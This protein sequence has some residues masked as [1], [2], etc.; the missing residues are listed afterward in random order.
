MPR[1]HAPLV[2]HRHVDLHHGVLDLLEVAAADGVLE[3]RVAGEDG[4]VVDHEADH[5]V[6]VPRRGH[7]IDPQITGFERVADD[8]HPELALVLDVVGVRVRPQNVGR[9][10]PPFLDRLEQRFQRSP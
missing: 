6:R 10:D 4:V 1:Q 7:R 8:G 9:C 3:E 2:R 5:V